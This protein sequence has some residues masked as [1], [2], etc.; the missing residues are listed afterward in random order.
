MYRLTVDAAD[1][2]AVTEHPD[3]DAAHG[4]LMR[5]VVTGDYYLRTVR[6]G[7]AHSTYEMLH[8]ADHRRRPRSAGHAVIEHVDPERRP[9][10]DPH[11][12]ADAACDWI[13][14]HE[15]A[16]RHGHDTDSR[17]GYPGAVLT[18]ARAEAR[19]WF[20]AGAALPEA[21]RLADAETASPLPQVRLEEL[22]RRAV[23][24][25]APLDARLADTVIAQL[26]PAAPASTTAALIWWYSLITWGA[27]A[28]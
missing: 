10:I 18:T 28:P 20:P 21:A 8:L 14:R 19:T 13:A 26:D 4:R 17:G 15:R 6:T 11:V 23:T 7:P 9:P 3:R 22:R 16:W 12:V 2:V 1:A 5:H 25:A 24:A 27:T